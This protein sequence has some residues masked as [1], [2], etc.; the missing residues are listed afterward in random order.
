[1]RR[2]TL[3]L[4]LGALVMSSGC[5]ADEGGEDPAEDVPAD[6]DLVASVDLAALDDDT[7]R[8]VLNTLLAES[9]RPGSDDPRTVEALLDRARERAETNVSVDGLNEVAVFARTPDGSTVGDVD[10]RESYAGVLVGASWDHEDVVDDLRTDADGLA[11]DGEHRDVTVYR[12]VEETANGTDRIYF[13]EYE[14]GL[15]TFASTRGAVEDVI[16]VAD[17]E[18]PAFGGDL[19]A[20]YDRT[21]ESAYVRYAVRLSETQ[22]Q[23][24]AA[25]AQRAGGGRVDLSP[26]ADVSVYAGAY[27]TERDEVGVSTYLRAEEPAAADRLNDTFDVL[28]DAGEALAPDNAT[29]QQFEA[30]S[31]DHE[32]RTVAV[33]YEI[34]AD[35]LGTLIEGTG[36]DAGSTPVSVGARDRDRDRDRHSPTVPRLPSLVPS[37][38]A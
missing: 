10:A 26:L 20:A 3:A 33:V 8:S 16:D 29:R 25:A 5:V 32:N 13:A 30:P 22:R 4:L 18:A 19:R 31:T 11:V 35:T 27:Y 38:G 36:D 23:S 7:T 6:V 28:V 37:R 9:A 14:E 12:A 17:G 2:T 21:R 34:D 15:W 1:M 24:I